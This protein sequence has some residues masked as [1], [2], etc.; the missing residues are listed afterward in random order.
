MEQDTTAEPE[1]LAIRLLF[2]YAPR[3]FPGFF[4]TAACRASLLIAPSYVFSK[5]FGECC[6]IFLIF[7]WILSGDWK[8]WRRCLREPV[9][10]ALLPW[11]VV[12]IVGTGYGIVDFPH[13]LRL[14]ISARSFLLVPILLTLWTDT[15]YKA[16]FCVFYNFAILLMF[17][18]IAA[19]SFLPLEGGPLGAFYVYAHATF[20]RAYTFIG[21]FALL[22]VILW[23][24]FPFAQRHV[25][26]LKPLWSEAALKSVRKLSSRD[27][28]FRVFL[29]RNFATWPGLVRLL[30][31]AAFL[32]FLFGSCRSRSAYI[33]TALVFFTVL[34]CRFAWK[35]LL[36]S[37][38]TLSVL[39]AGAVFLTTLVEQ[40][41]PRWVE[42]V[43][44]FRVVRDVRRTLHPQPD[45]ARVWN[46]FRASIR[47]R[48]DFM[49]EGWKRFRERPL[50][51]FG[52]GSVPTVMLG[53]EK[54][55]GIYNSAHSEYLATAIQWGILGL[56][57]FFFWLAVFLVRIP[58]LPRPNRPALFVLFVLMLYCFLVMEMLTVG[59]LRFV[60]LTMIVFLLPPCF[61]ADESETDKIAFL[62]IDR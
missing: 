29:H 32:A 25:R 20:V 43:S 39:I 17:A 18:L 4:H 38:I 36:V 9:A 34:T 27:A 58:A 10:W 19:V 59:V 30:F 37:A 7:A 44:L 48:A 62:E 1:S 60:L 46:S 54:Y 57:V 8:H 45:D 53:I 55:S 49:E 40:T 51:G 23:V 12:M 21:Q 6:F 5:T 31:F 61:P 15:H 11:M 50:L 56:G 33:C 52:S 22:S 47:V 24:Y 13:R 41:N 35:G 42:N 16:L 3:T 2:G 14:L 26:F 28:P